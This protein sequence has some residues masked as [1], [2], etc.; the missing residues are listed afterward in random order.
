MKKILITGGTGFIG[1]HLSKKCL[2]MKWNVTSFSTKT[3]KNIR[4]LKNVN[5][6]ICDLTKR[7][8]LEKKLKKK[9]FDFIVNLSGH[10]D[11]NNKINTLNSHFKSVQNLIDSLRNNF[12]KKF[13]QMGSSAEYGGRSKPQKES[14][15]CK[16]KSIYGNA[17]LKTTNYLIN[18]YKKYSFPL[19]VLRLYQAYGPYQDINRLIPIVIDACKKNQPF[20]CSDGNQFR[21]FIYIDDIID[22]IIKCLINKN[23]SGKI[24]NLGSGKVQKIKSIISRISRYY[25][26]GTPL[27]GKIK[28]RKDESKL[29]VANI[30]KI[31]KEINWKPKTKFNTGLKETLKYYGKKKL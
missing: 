29:I 4:K 2:K 14:A 5:Y 16:A 22:A 31:K 18:Q 24:Y 8:E 6:V 17:K 13:I 15:K 25:K 26:G 10:V 9:K 19:T 12:P 7:K 11:H 28:L 20:N 21:D 23:S 27:F 3:P 1:Y 30:H